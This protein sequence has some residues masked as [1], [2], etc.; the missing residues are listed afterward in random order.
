MGEWGW[1]GPR[2]SSD[3]VEKGKFLTLPGLELQPLGCPARSQLLH[4]FCYL[5]LHQVS[6]ILRK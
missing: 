5:G 1:E 6:N 4:R 2:A 3:D